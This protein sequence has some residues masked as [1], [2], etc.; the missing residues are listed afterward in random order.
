MT[1]L[2]VDLTMILFAMVMKE[3]LIACHKRGDRTEK[4]GND[5]LEKPT[6]VYRCLMKMTGFILLES[7]ISFKTIFDRVSFLWHYFCFTS[8]QV[9]DFSSFMAEGQSVTSFYSCINNV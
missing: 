9:W 8:V 4:L 1:P 5:V 3:S 7:F 6:I 2:T